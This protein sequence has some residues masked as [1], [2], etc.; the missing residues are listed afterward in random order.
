ML[1]EPF[2]WLR[3]LSSS[4][5]QTPGDKSSWTAWHFDWGE[6]VSTAFV[7]V[8]KQDES[9]ETAA[10]SLSWL[11]VPSGPTHASNTSFS[12]LDKSEE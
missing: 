5:D 11:P 12:S 6:G 7:L 4:N 3:Y 1:E 8:E 9:R 10:L 2:P